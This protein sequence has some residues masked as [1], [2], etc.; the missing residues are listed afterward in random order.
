MSVDIR[1]QT[2]SK[3]LKKPDGSSKISKVHTEIRQ[4]GYNDL[5]EM[6]LE[7]QGTKKTGLLKASDLLSLVEDKRQAIGTKQSDENSVRKTALTLAKSLFKDESSR[8][9]Y[10][11]F[12]AWEKMD[13]VLQAVV[14]QTTAIKQLDRAIGISLVND[15]I[16]ASA[17]GTHPISKETAIEYIDAALKANQASWIRPDEAELLTDQ[18]QCIACR[19]LIPSGTNICTLCGSAQSVSCPKC[20]SEAPGNAE[21]CPHC[22]FEFSQRGHVE[23]LLGNAEAAIDTLQLDQ[24]KDLIS[25]AEKTWPGH[26]TAQKL[27]GEIE[28]LS[29]LLGSEIAVFEAAWNSNRFMSAQESYER[30]RTLRPNFQDERFESECKTKVHEAQKLALEAQHESGSRRLEVAQLAYNLV[31]DLPEV[32]ALFS[33]LRPDA[34]TS[35]EVTVDSYSGINSLKWHISSPQDAQY[36]VLRKERSQPTS[37]D[38]SEVIGVITQTTF[39]DNKPVPGIEYYY[40]VFAQVGPERSSLSHASS[41]VIN[42]REIGEYSVQTGSQ[43]VKISWTA[44]EN[45]SAIAAT[46]TSTTGEVT[47][48]SNINLAQLLDSDLI[49]GQP[50]SYLLQVVYRVNGQDVLSPGIRV[51]AT[52]SEPPTPVDWILATVKD[53]EVRVQWDVPNK[54]KVIFVVLTEAPSLQVGDVLSTHDFSRAGYFEA[55]L[56]SSTSGEGKLTLSDNDVYHLLAFTVDDEQY[57][58]GASTVVSKKSSPEI[59]NIVFSGSQA[60]CEFDWPEDSSQVLI[61]YS[62]SGFPQSETDPRAQRVPVRKAQYDIHRAISIPLPEEGQLYISLYAGIGEGGNITWMAPTHKHINFGAKEE[63][64]YHVTVSKS[65]FGKTNGAKLVINSKAPLPEL[66]LRSQ[67]GQIPVIAGVGDV[68]LTIP[69]GSPAGEYP[70]PQLYTQKGTYFRLWLANESAYSQF[71]LIPTPGKNT[72]IG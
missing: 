16:A 66:V 25:L 64:T 60:R 35:L 72:M 56:E 34:P 2:E 32:V 29:N 43:K 22:S 31:S 55:D 37:P 3:A 45:T 65:L 10:D 19:H 27:Q 1:Q 71:D 30:L 17:A 15:L 21:Y 67:V 49:N 4:Y 23:I 28:Q 20:G 33:G 36:V 57:V 8:E 52:P 12:L 7:G 69:S 38:D 6:L 53:G 59:K 54:G 58:A 24:A 5:Y 42:L 39:V 9:K 63:I 50:Y 18:V 51:E 41:A 61:A 68:A 47:S 14:L 62:S 44:P 11:E 26:P 13:A 48:V 46:R 70:I 40:A